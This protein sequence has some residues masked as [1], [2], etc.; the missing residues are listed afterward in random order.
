MDP[1]IK[2]NG[3]KIKDTEKEY[4]NLNKVVLKE[5]GKMIKFKVQDI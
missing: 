1:V 2:D 3:K 4:L 5:N